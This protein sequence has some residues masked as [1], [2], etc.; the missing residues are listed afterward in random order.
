M[1]KREFLRRHS[2]NPALTWREL[3]NEAQTETGKL[4]FLRLAEETEKQFA[5][6]PRLDVDASIKIGEDMVLYEEL[7]LLADRGPGK[8]ERLGWMLSDF[9]RGIMA[10]AKQ[11]LSNFF[12]PLRLAWESLLEYPK[13]YLLVAAL[14]L[15]L[16]VKGL[17]LCLAVLGITGVL[18]FFSPR[19][20]SPR[21]YRASYVFRA[22]LPTFLLAFS[23]N[24]I[25]TAVSREPPTFDDGV[26][27]VSGDWALGTLEERSLNSNVQIS[28]VK[29]TRSLGQGIVSVSVDKDFDWKQYARLEIAEVKGPAMKTKEGTPLRITTWFWVY[30]RLEG[31]RIKKENPVAIPKLGLHMAASDF[32]NRV[33]ATIQTVS[34]PQTGNLEPTLGD[35]AGAVESLSDPL[36][37]A[38][39]V[40]VE[41][42]ERSEVLVNGTWLEIKK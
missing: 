26:F 22:L 23:S 15:F 12:Y 40:K 30:Y 21:E 33:K 1:N 13:I 42:S 2:E 24:F 41:T 31:A 20:R 35:Y 17:I 32:N 9:A 5:N 14:F 28:F 38:V 34:S 3:A 10:S 39:V 6:L 19:S 11:A 8:Y 25:V 37:Q 36:F 29:T 18:L 16:G 4:A 27:L 7:L